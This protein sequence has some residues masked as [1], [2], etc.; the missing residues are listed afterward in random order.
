MSSVT[1]KPRTTSP[2]GDQA[3]GLRALIGQRA[4]SSAAVTS[5]CR[6][7][8]VT[9][10]KGGVGKSV[11]TLNIAVALAERGAKV[12]VLDGNVGLGNLDL[13]CNRNGY[14][15]L[16][17]VV[18]GSRRLADVVLDGPGGIQLMPGAGSLTD[19]GDCPDSARLQLL[20]ELEQFAARYDF[21]LFDT[22]SGQHDTVRR[23]AQA[24]DE[25]LIV[26][27][28]EPTAIADAYATLKSLRSGDRTAMHIAVNQATAEQTA[29]IL[30]RI[31]QTAHT[32]LHKSL[33]LGTGIPNDPAVP[34]SV[35]A[36]TPFVTAAP[37]CSA[38]RAVRQLARQLIASE[39]PHRQG[40]YFE[41]LCIERP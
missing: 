12:C 21:L 2:L 39:P 35:L 17:H 6:T 29:R 32:F 8:A 16:S 41:R 28:P 5:R 40:S 26:T 3:R 4:A 25:V 23:L 38:S 24:A 30:E 15:N 13:L 37:E 36:R 19:L 18:T 14:W 20:G 27:T 33:S 11:L 1:L 22:G 31:Q 34:Q 9:S 7:L 10:G